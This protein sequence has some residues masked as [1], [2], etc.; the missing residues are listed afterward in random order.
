MDPMAQNGAN[1]SFERAQR[2]QNH[3]QPPRKQ[4]SFG[5]QEGFVFEYE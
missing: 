5:E 1:R 4:F 2:Y 3:V